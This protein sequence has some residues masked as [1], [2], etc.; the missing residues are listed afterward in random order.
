MVIY[1]NLIQL[2]NEDWKTSQ[3]RERKRERERPNVGAQRTMQSTMSTRRTNK[4]KNLRAHIKKKCKRIE[5]GIKNGRHRRFGLHAA[6]II[7]LSTRSDRCT[8]CNAIIMITQLN[9][10]IWFWLYNLALC[11]YHSR[12]LN[13]IWELNVLAC[14]FSFRITKTNTHHIFP[15]F[16]CTKLNFKCEQQTQGWSFDWIPCE[17]NEPC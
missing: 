4:R 3:A 9:Q 15:S 5:M 6:N 16:F 14:I 11:F 10:P 17:F 2:R 13:C 1:Y 7:R 8:I 12:R